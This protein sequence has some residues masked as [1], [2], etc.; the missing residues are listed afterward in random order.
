MRYPYLSILCVLFINLCSVVN[1]A[2]GDSDVPKAQPQPLD[3]QDTPE[4]EKVIPLPVGVSEPIA[5][6]QCSPENP[7]IGTEVSCL[8]R[9]QHSKTF[10]VSIG[11]PPG[12]SA[13]PQTV[14]PDQKQNGQ[15]VT[16]RQVSLTPLSMRKVKLFGF[17]STWSH[18]S[19]AKGTVLIKDEYMPMA[20]MMSDVDE[21]T[22]RTFRGPV[23]DL[24][25]FWSRH[26]VLPLIET[27]WFLVVGI[28]VIVL[29][30]LL[31][32]VI[33]YIQKVR[34]QK[35]VA[36]AP[37]VDPRPAHVIANESLEAL[38]TE[39]LPEQGLTLEF[40]LR[41][42]EIL[43]VFLENRFGIAIERGRGADGQITGLRFT[44]ATTEEIESVLRVNEKISESGLTALMECLSVIDYVVFGGIRPHVG[45]T[46]SDRRR[47]RNCIDLNKRVEA[48]VPELLSEMSAGSDNLAEDASRPSVPDEVAES[49]EVSAVT[50][51]LDSESSS[52]T[53]PD[54]RSQD[55]GD[56]R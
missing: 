24:N 52:V 54:V 4:P 49:T 20:S 50:P 17:A 6:R 32:L 15:L 27:N 28:M 48:E 9:I 56:E 19:G 33:V 55:S 10:S 1:A 39:A 21:P 44:A 7:R 34:A 11:V 47:I 13:S 18:E 14:V 41:L 45:Q 3:A 31:A 12:F 42:S 46:E 26:G 29:G 8:I 51:A 53:T 2:P 35:R 43:R 22:F 37:W 16:T 23:P 40:Y 30:G 36:E 25:T 38:A 5:S